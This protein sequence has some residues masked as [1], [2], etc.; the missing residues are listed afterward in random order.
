MKTVKKEVGQV[1]V[2]LD[3]GHDVYKLCSSDSNQIFVV[4]VRE[5]IKSLNLSYLL[6][7]CFKLVFIHFLQ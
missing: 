4:R 1:C 6:G 3:D 2:R 7:S 5:K